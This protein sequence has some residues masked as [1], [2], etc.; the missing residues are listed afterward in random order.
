MAQDLIWEQ[1]RGGKL[2]VKSSL[3][4]TELS[5][6]FRRFVIERMSHMDFLITI[7]WYFSPFT[8]YYMGKGSQDIHRKGLE[9]DEDKK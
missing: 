8:F 4:F 3:N 1:Q 6:G 2:L 9:C 7:V 5:Q